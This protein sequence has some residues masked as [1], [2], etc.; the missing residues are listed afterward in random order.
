MST[1]ISILGGGIA[2]LSTAI[3]LQRLGL[4]ITVF[5]ASPT[6]EPIGAGL[7]LASNAM[8][9]LDRLGI[10]ESVIEAGTAIKSVIIKDHKGKSIMIQ[11]TENVGA[12]YGWDNYAVHRA[13]LHQILERSFSGEIQTDK[14]AVSATQHQKGVRVVFEDGTE[15]LTDFLIVADGIHSGIRQSLIPGA[16]PRYAGYT[17]WRAVIEDT[18]LNLKEA[19]ETWGS[20][21]RFG[22]VPLTNKRLYWFACVNAPEE[23]KTLQAFTPDDLYKRFRDFHSPIPEIIRATHNRDLIWNDIADVRPLDHFAFGNIVLIGDAA[24]ATTPNLGQGACMAIEDAVILSIEMGKNKDY[25]KAFQNFELRRLKRTRWITTTSKK[26]GWA[27]Q[28]ENPLLIRVRNTVA[29]LIPSR[30][31]EGQIEELYQVDLS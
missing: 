6:L 23:S 20:K 26:I 14:R 11:N 24:H 10:A 1:S 22:F 27:A 7:V 15:Q 4:S 8:K 18:G 29:R 3:A 13:D 2:G 28:I 30:V 17:C 21:G 31:K 5:E 9:G 19:Y 16:T 25:Q 12:S